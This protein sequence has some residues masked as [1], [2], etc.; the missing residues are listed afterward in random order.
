M[1][2]R[3]LN[4]QVFILKNW[5]V[6]PPQ[7]TEQILG[8]KLEAPDNKNYTRIQKYLYPGIIVTP[9][10]PDSNRILKDLL[11]FNKLRRFL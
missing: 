8:Y 4:E 11:K 2:I 5:I 10:G 9:R 1:L 6:L 3:T 7:I